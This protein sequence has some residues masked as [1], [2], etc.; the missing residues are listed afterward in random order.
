[1]QNPVWEETFHFDIH[2]GKE[3]IKVSIMDRNMVKQDTV[4]GVLYIPIQTLID[5]QKVED[6]FNL[7]NPH[8]GQG[9]SNGRIRLQLWWIHSK[10]KLIEDR[11]VQ[12][13]EDIDKIYSDKQYYQDK[14]VQLREPFAWLEATAE[15]TSMSASKGTA[16]RPSYYSI[17]NYKEEVESEDE[18]TMTNPIVS[19]TNKIRGPERSLARGFEQYTDGFS[20]SFL[21]LRSTPW[22]KIMQWFNVIYCILTLCTCFIRSDF[23]NLTVCVLIC[24]CVSK[25]NT[26]KRWQFRLIVVGLIMSWLSDILWMI[27]H[28]S[29]WWAPANYDGDCELALRRFVVIVTYL[30]FIFRVFIFLVFWKLSVDFNR[31][32]KGRSDP[33]ESGM[34]MGKNYI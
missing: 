10:T 12:T 11:I 20:Y 1:M 15:A 8:G 21:G 23:I 17:G 14:I 28:T 18:E 22:F 31:L 30:S 9:D 6:W 33:S 26:L 5:Q 16:N 32:V 3:E 29:S 4:V 7:E 13:D 24:Y 2:N 19:A 27:F 34:M 25:L